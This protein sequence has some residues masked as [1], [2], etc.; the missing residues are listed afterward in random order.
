MVFA[1][2]LFFLD[3][4]F[5]DALGGC[6]VPVVAMLTDNWLARDGPSRVQ[7]RLS[8][9]TTCS[10]PC[11]SRRNRR[12]RGGLSWARLPGRREPGAGRRAGH[13]TC[14]WPP[15]SAPTSCVP[16]TR[17]RGCAS[18]GTASCTTAC[19]RRRCRTAAFRDRTRLVRDG[20]L[21]LLFAGRLVDLKGA[22]TAVEALPLYA[23]RREG[24]PRGPGDPP[25][26]RR[27]RAG[28]RPTC[29][30]CTRPS[31]G[32]AARTGSSCARPCRR[33]PCSTCSRSTTS[34][35]SPRSTSRSR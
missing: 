29:S 8:S 24:G 10:G 6:G 18:P 16:T 14:P 17:R 33:P 31:P 15:S 12:R 20:E 1:W 34:T 21:R 30:A 5:L 22:D 3:R 4:S 13:R 27:G 32:P 19:P 11:R 7:R 28:R 23:G 2:N 35:C 9:A 25:D 26:G